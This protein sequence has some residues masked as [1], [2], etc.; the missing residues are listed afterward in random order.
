MSLH[1]KFLHR[2]PCCE[3]NTGLGTWQMTCTSWNLHHAI[4]LAV[5][6][7]FLITSRSF[8]AVFHSLPGAEKD[9]WYRFL[10]N[11]CRHPYFFEAASKISLPASLWLP[12]V[13][14]HQNLNHLGLATSHTH[15]PNGGLKLS[16]CRDQDPHYHFISF[17]YCVESQWNS[18]SVTLK[19]QCK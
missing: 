16:R 11:S 5:L 13:R 9:S 12:H 7:A 19:V 1:C 14:Y 3:A 2:T 17:T 6:A 10:P 4:S 8:G 15:K 18:N